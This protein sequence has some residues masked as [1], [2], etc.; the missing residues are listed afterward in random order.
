[1]AAL[2]AHNKSNTHPTHKLTLKRLLF[3]SKEPL[4]H[5][6]LLCAF[7]ENSKVH[8]ARLLTS[9]YEFSMH[10]NPAFSSLFKRLLFKSSIPLFNIILTYA[11]QFYDL[12]QSQLGL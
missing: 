4:Q 6:K 9:L 8:G 7:M 10:G 1:M 3:W 2:D 11:L 12:T 5:I